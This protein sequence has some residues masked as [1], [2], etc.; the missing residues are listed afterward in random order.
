MLNIEVKRLVHE[1]SQEHIEMASDSLT[2][3]LDRIEATFLTKS[4]VDSLIK[5]LK[6]KNALAN[7][8]YEENDKLKDMLKE[9]AK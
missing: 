9:L 7:E 3:Y 5:A 4:M 1:A 8:L 2:K 6:D